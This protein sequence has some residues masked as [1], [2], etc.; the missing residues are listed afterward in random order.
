[1]QDN[2]KDAIFMY[3]KNGRAQQI[4]IAGCNRYGVTNCAVD[5]LCAWAFDKSR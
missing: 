5:G 2:A 3:Q 1:M 4:D